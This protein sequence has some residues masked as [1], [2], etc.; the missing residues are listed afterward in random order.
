MTEK[1]PT[2]EGRLDRARIRDRVPRAAR[3]AGGTALAVGLGAS[4]FAVAGAV[5][6][7]GTAAAALDSASTATPPS[8][9]SAPSAI[10]P[11]GPVTWPGGGGGPGRPPPGRH[12]PRG[13]LLGTVS[14]TGSGTITLRTP[15]GAS[16]T[17]TVNASTTYRQG[18]RS[19]TSGQVIVGED[20]AVLPTSATAGTSSP[21]AA[22]IVVVGPR[23]EGRVVSVSGQTLVV[24]DAQGFYRTVL[25]S[26]ST[27]VTEA[28]TASALTAVTPGTKIAAIGTIASDHTDLD[29]TAIR[30]LLPRV[31]GKVTAVDTS[32]GTITLSAPGTTG[33][34]TV[35]TTSST[36]FRKG[37]SS[38][39]L[40]AIPVGS[41]VVAIGTPGSGNSLAALE[42]VVRPPGHP[43]PGHGPGPGWGPGRSR[44]QQRTG[45]SRGGAGTTTT[46]S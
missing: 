34:T 6:T 27:S 17:V 30:I 24:A 25:T 33:S 19:L 37:A 4:G 14:A 11:G 42:V 2:N 41:L 16:V 1:D 26:T 29:A 28:G 23:I 36:T 46:T 35:T 10:Q 45:S 32:T 13:G 22:T 40:S 12:R 43:F 5:G 8:P 31:V 3:I 15:R 38:T 7:A 20:V 21:T 39:T 18:R 44:F 9:P